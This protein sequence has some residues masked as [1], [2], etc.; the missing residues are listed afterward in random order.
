LSRGSEET[1]II[2]VGE[3]ALA[4][5]KVVINPKDELDPNNPNLTNCPCCGN[6]ASRWAKPCPKCGYD[7]A[8]HFYAIAEAKRK[9]ELSRRAMIFFGVGV[10]ALVLSGTHWLPKSW[11]FPLVL[12]GLGALIV[13]GACGKAADK[14]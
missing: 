5:K 6:L 2:A 7:I 11:E 13:G 1:N 12:V 8:E 14:G 9:S 10:A 3:G 4:A